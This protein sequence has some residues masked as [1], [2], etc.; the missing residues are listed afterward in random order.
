MPPNCRF[1]VDDIES[2]WPY[3]ENE[4]FDFIHA[5]SICGAIKDWD[6]LF[7]QCYKH[8]KTGGW[9]EIQEYEAWVKSDDGGM[10]KAV[11]VKQWQQQID[12]ASTQFG[13]KMNI[14]ETLK[15][16]LISQGF[17]EVHD[18]P[19]KVSMGLPRH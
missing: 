12:D 15:D 4:K 13:K 11:N 9:V 18:D 19:Y 1:M 2:E 7:R 16:R 6:E 8:L 17:H 5:R 3:R 14:A 10:E